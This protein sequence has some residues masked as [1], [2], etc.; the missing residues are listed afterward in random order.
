MEIYVDDMLIKS[1]KVAN[2]YG[3]FERLRKHTLRLNLGDW[4]LSFFKSMKQVRSSGRTMRAVLPR[5]GGVPVTGGLLQL[6]SAGVCP[7]EPAI[8]SDP[9]RDEGKIRRLVL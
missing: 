2:F 6:H 5:M 7:V 4:S 9:I 8:N 1:Q 3:I